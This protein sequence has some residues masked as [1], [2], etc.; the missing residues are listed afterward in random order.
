MGKDIDSQDPSK[1]FQIGPINDQGAAPDIKSFAEDE[2]KYTPVNLQT[3]RPYFLIPFADEDDNVAESDPKQKEVLLDLAEATDRVKQYVLKS[4]PITDIYLV[5]HGWHR[6]LYGATSAYDRII[7]RFSTLRRRKRIAPEAPY[8]PLFLTLHWHSDLGQNS[9]VDHLGRRDRDSFMRLAFERIT[10]REAPTNTGT[11]RTD[12]ENLFE[13][14]VKMSSADIDAM[15]PGIKE[16]AEDLSHLFTEYTIKDAREATPDEVVACI[17]SCYH[18]AGVAKPVSE[19]QVAP[20]DFC[21]VPAYFSTA[22]QVLTGVFGILTLLGLLLKSNWLVSGWAWLESW[23]YR[24]TI[25][26]IP[27]YTIW[28]DSLKG[29]FWSLIC[30]TILWIVVLLG[31]STVKASAK[32]STARKK[33]TLGAISMGA[34]LILQL[35]HSIPI[36][37]FCIL[38]PVI[39]RPLVA[40]AAAGAVVWWASN[41]GWH[42]LLWILVPLL[43][44][45]YRAC[46]FQE[47]VEN[48]NSL[49]SQIGL[50]SRKSLVKIAR[51]PIKIVKSVSDA[52]SRSLHLWQALDNQFAFWDMVEKAVGSAKRASDWLQKTVAEIQEKSP[53]I[54]PDT[55]IHLLGHSHGGLLVMNLAR[56]ITAMRANFQPKL[57]TVTTINGAY[58]SKW[59][60]TEQAVIDNVQGCIASV[61]SRY[62]TANSVWYPIA[63]SGRRSSGFVG[64]YL[65]DSPQIVATPLPYAFLSATPN[66]A[67]RI[68]KHEAGK[69]VKK[70]KVL[71]IDG[72]RLIFDG[73]ILPQGSHG[74]IYKDEVIQLMWATTQFERDKLA[75]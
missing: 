63:N 50:W 23:I 61:Y 31:V 54:G 22:F 1:R 57:Q 48:C 25:A 4:D 3:T 60:H 49:I 34:W 21:S 19:Q 37:I 38:S 11:M 55:R 42:L 46:L 62:D 47:R 39:S 8:N 52:D 6:N 43:F 2:P 44:T 68:Q 40:L 71:N 69:D 24:G 75:I 32:K 59:L 20:S 5:S 35:F 14:F 66:L 16:D 45:L 13:L 17:W 65:P 7:S 12:M 15:A 72:S 53:N 58:M 64:F 9:W 29:L 41:E 67:Q 36:L 73:P 27:G 10:K 33:P 74:D 28:N 30:F 56:E 51:F 18:E 26:V 70:I